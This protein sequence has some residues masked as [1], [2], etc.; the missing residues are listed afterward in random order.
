MI[1]LNRHCW[2]VSK[3]IHPTYWEQAPWAK[4]L[5]HWSMNPLWLSGLLSSMKT[6]LLV[7][8][9]ITPLSYHDYW[10]HHQHHHFCCHQYN[11]N[12]VFAT[13]HTNCWDG[14][15]PLHERGLL[16]LVA[17]AA[18]PLCEA[19]V[20]VTGSATPEQLWYQDVGGNSGACGSCYQMCY[21]QINIYRSW[22]IKRLLKITND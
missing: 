18:T 21:E 13:P 2:L 22:R 17:L 12:D 15:L 1:S 5:V 6:L 11:P 8:F 14:L 19:T 7:E 3:V 20:L 16:G 9:I 10:F 4:Q